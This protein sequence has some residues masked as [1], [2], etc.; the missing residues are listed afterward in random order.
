MKTS[1]LPNLQR[2]LTDM[3][4]GGSLSDFRSWTSGT[5]GTGTGTPSA[6]GSSGGTFWE[7]LGSSLLGV[8]SVIAAIKGNPGTVNQFYTPPQ[9][10]ANMAFGAML[11]I[12][13]I[14]G[15][16]IVLIV[17]IKPKSS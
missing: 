8:S 5:P 1:F 3:P 11:P 13:L 7:T 10:N 6:S 12:L 15:V 4:S 17:M 2:S 16:V 9:P 14:V